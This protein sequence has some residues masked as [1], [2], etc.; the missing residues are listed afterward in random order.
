M[1]SIIGHSYE[2]QPSSGYHLVTNTLPMSYVLANCATISQPLSSS[3]SSISSDIMLMSSGST[4]NN[5]TNNTNSTNS[6]QQQKMNMNQSL[7][8][9]SLRIELEQ[10]KNK[11]HSK[12]YECNKLR[13]Q[14]KQ[15]ST[16]IEQYKQILSSF[17]QNHGTTDPNAL[18]SA[19]NLFPTLALGAAAAAAVT[20]GSNATSAN[21]MAVLANAAARSPFKLVTT[22]GGTSQSFVNLST[23]GS[24]T[25]GGGITKTK[26][27]KSKGGHSGGGNKKKS[28][29]GNNNCNCCCD[30]DKPYICDWVNCGKRFRQKPHLEAHRNIH[31]GRRF[32][33][34]WPNCGKSFVRKYNLAEHQKLHSSVNP[35]MCTYP[36]CGKVF[37]SKYSL[38]RHQ[39]AQHNLNL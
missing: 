22:G 27:T 33:C 9:Q 2:H 26:D 37:S 12:T 25:N 4:S 19:T 11:L 20:Q 5:Y 17:T 7:D 29:T 1:Q 28:S 8:S 21:V 32:I 36:D 16:E 34:D 24:H 10:T 15:F 3:S 18:L 30:V 23:I 31:T 35:N 6:N 39:N 38:M 14:L 13:Q